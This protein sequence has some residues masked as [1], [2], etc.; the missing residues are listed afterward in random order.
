[1]K[2]TFEVNKHV[3][4]PEHK[5]LNDKEKATL[6]EKYYISPNNL[7]R[8]LKN[9]KAISELKV[10]EGDVIKVIRPSQTAGTTKF[11]RVVVN[12]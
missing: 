1:M 7:P 12:E 5:K 9:D 2:T 3:L 6:L 8:I 11:Y 4:V 10:E